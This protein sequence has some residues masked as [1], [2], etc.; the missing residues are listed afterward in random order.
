VVSHVLS[1]DAARVSASSSSALAGDME[2]TRNQYARA[3]HQS[4]AAGSLSKQSMVWVVSP[5]WAETPIF[6]GVFGYCTQKRRFVT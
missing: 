6:R 3:I 4:R 1:L 2:T 5:V